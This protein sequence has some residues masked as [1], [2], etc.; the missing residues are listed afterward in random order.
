MS[1]LAT[2]LIRLYPREWRGRYGAEMTE[3]LASER[4]T[5][6]SATDLVAGAIDARLNRQPVPGNPAAGVE[7]GTMTTRMFHCCSTKYS[8]QD[9]L[10]SA[11]WMVGGCFGMTLVSVAL[12][13]SFGRNSLSEALLYG[14]FPAALILSNEPTYFRPYSQAARLTMS[15]GGALLVLLMMWGFVLIGERI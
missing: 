15:I 14:A 12:Q 1:G 2:A 10:R 11:A 7:G 13:A 9:Q 3:M 4:L 8:R 6:R 5:L